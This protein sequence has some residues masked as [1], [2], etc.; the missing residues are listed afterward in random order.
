MDD[1]ES[2]QEDLR[3]QVAELEDLID[4]WEQER[5]PESRE[6]IQLLRDAIDIKLAKLRDI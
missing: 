2:R 5:E 4:H 6:I 3:N 1:R